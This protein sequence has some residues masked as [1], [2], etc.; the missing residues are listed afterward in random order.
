QASTRARRRQE[1][2]EE[3]TLSHGSHPALPP[4]LYARHH[5][6]LLELLHRYAYEERDVVLASGKPSRFYID[7]KQAVLTAE[8]HFL[9]GW[10]INHVLRAEEIS[11]IGGLSVGADPLA[12]AT[13]TLSFLGPR[14]L[15]A[16]YVRKEPKGHGTRA[17]VEGMKALG[18]GARVAIV[19]DVVT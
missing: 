5:A 15:G 3:E 11:A 14:P 1:E 7:C 17:Y 10:L 8:G 6:R 2:A 16:F 19:E 18:E 9:A 12:S 4:E 13:S